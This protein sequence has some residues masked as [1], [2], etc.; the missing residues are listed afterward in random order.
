MNLIALLPQKE[1]S[2]KPLLRSNY[3]I[4]KIDANDPA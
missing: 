1:N 2:V 4:S 3:F